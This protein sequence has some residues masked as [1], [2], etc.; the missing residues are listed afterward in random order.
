MHLVALAAALALTMTAPTGTLAIEHVAVISMA[1]DEPL[2]LDHT[3]LVEGGRVRAIEPSAS[4]AVPSGAR[5]IDGAG[6]FLMPGL[7]DM[8]CH[9]LS[10]DRIADRFA[11]HELTMIL[12]N[13]VTT[14]RN[15]IGKPEHLALRERLTAGE[16]LGPQLFVASPQ[17]AGRRFGKVFNGVAVKTPEG[18]EAAVRRFHA[19]GYD[20]I[21]LTF[22]ITRPVFDAVARTAS[23]LGLPVIGHVGPEVGLE[24]ALEVGMQIEHLD[25]YLEA[26]LDDESPERESLSGSGVYRNWHTVAHLD[27][28]RIPELVER[29]RAAGTWS[30]PTS[31]FLHTAFAVGRSDAEIEAAPDARFVSD[32]VRAELLEAHQRYWAHPPPAGARSRFVQLRQAIVLALWEAGAPLMAGSDAPEWMLLGGFSL[33]RELEELAAAGLPNHAVL[34]AAT[35]VPARFLERSDEQGTLEVGKRADLLLLDANPLEEIANTRRIAGVALAGEWFDRAALDALLES[36]ARELAAA[37]L[38]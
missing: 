27:P 4:C 35:I 16:V 10:D 25:E 32:E 15:P 8:H 19:E 3:V 1:G 11:V 17:L 29:V 38:R 21:K 24:R 14:I 6:R 5:R 18:A 34:E 13:G 22:R 33:H 28:E 12:A 2:L 37:P 7:V 30:T 20:S 36:S 26:L 9:F 31:A 23:E